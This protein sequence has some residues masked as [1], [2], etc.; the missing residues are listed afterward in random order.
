[1]S[2]E[3]RITKGETIVSVENLELWF[4]ND[5]GSIKVLNGIDWK[6]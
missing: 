3:K 2:E 6:F 4:D 1:M 5:Y